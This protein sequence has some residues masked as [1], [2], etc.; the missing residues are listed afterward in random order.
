MN[1]FMDFL[2]LYIFIILIIIAFIITIIKITK[3]NKIK[4][5]RQNVLINLSLSNYK[6]TTADYILQVKSSRAVETFNDIKFFKENKSIFNEAVDIIKDK[7][8]YKNKLINF[9]NN[10]QYKSNK[11][12]SIIEEEIN[13][14]LSY[15]D[16]Y[17]IL[18]EYTS[19]AGNVNTKII[20][21]I[22]NTRIMELKNDPTLL[23]NKTQISNYTKNQLNNKKHKYYDTINNIIDYANTNRNLM[24]N[25]KLKNNLDNLVSI[26]IDNPINNIQ[27][28]KDIDSP[29]WN[30]ISTKIDNIYKD[31]KILINKNN[32]I[33]NYYTSNKFIE[34]K[35]TYNT[36]LG[37]QIEFNNYIDEK[38]KSISKLF[39]TNIV[40]NETQYD[41]NY[42]H[43]YK[44]SIDPFTAE[45]S[46]TVF[47]SAENK[48][49]DYIIKY[50]YSNCSN[51]DKCVEYIQNLK[52]LIEELETLEDAKK[53][54]DTCK[55]EFEKY[56]IDV[57]KYVLNLD[58]NGFYNRLGFAVINENSITIEYKF[59]YTSN[60]GRSQKS[61]TVPMTENNII[62]LINKLQHNLTYSN[63]AKEQRALMTS[64]LRNYIL[65]RDNYTCQICKN[66]I[67][68]EPNLLM[69]ID[70][71]K[72]ISKG[73]YT[74]ENNLQTLCW[75]CNRH[76]SSKY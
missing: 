56:L 35:R 8:N 39:G 67:Y 73:G 37:S 63:F 62:S 66:S 31:I 47:A 7:Q 52:K 30:V 45:V 75:K 42:I 53:I 9:L 32:Q 69:E 54:I 16:H 2:P 15:L 51:K 34:L 70:H 20:Y 44:K 72:P 48:P 10:N 25:E 5:L 21:K 14:N 41:D 18:V 49:L 12:Y 1:H 4:Q 64:K 43:L 28:I 23:M 38:I 57:P 61:F 60:S 22:T 13:D 71:I 6:Y 29:E 40:R 26:L 33:I 55:K 3:E 27:K 59:S 76:K 50:F 36:L 68:K 17:I 46:A 58:E 24:V 74:I 65:K 11:Y 19:P